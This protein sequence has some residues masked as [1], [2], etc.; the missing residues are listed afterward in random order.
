MAALLVGSGRA[1]GPVAVRAALRQGARDLGPPGVDREYGS[2]L[3]QALGAL[4]VAAGETAAPPTPRPA[5]PRPADRFSG[6][7]SKLIAA[8]SLTGA[9]LLAGLAFVWLARRRRR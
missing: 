1:E 2:G 3:V 4:R 6:S 5:A 7:G 8:L 9:G